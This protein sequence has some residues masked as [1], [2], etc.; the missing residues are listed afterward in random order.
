MVFALMAK[1]GYEVNY[2]KQNAKKAQVTFTVDEYSLEQVILNGQNFSAINFEGNVVTKDKGYAELPYL[3]TNIQLTADK[4]VDITVIDSD[5]TDI[6]LENPLK[7]SRGVIYRNQDPET[8][9]YTINP[10]S[11]KD[12]WYPTQLAEQ[13]MPFI[14]RDIRGT[15]I[16]V[17]PFRYNAVTNTL[18]VYN[19]VTV[20]VTENNETATNPLQA[21]SSKYYR[22]M[23]GIY[24]S[25]FINYNLSKQDLTV[26]EAGDLLVITTDRDLE[27]IQPYVQ[28]KQEKGF[29]VFVE[30]VATGTNVVDLI[31]TKYDE[32]PELLYV[33]LV[34]D[35]ADV[36]VDTD[37]G[38][39]VDPMA[40]CVVGTDVFQDICVGR[41]SAS[42]AAEVTVQ[43]NKTIQYE[44]NPQED[45]EWYEAALGIG[46]SEGASNGDDSEMDK[47]HIQII[48]DNKLDPFTFNNYYPNYDPGA[49]ATTVGNGV[50]AG[51]SWINYCGHGSNT[52][53]VTSGF[54]NNNVNALTNG[55][56]LPGIISVACVNGAYHSGTCFAEAWMRKEN[57]GA[58]ATLM[59]TIN[60][61]WQ[62]P[63]R[64]QD[65]INDI[66]VGGYDYNNNPGNGINTTEQ[67]TT[68][69][70]LAANGM[71]LL[72]SESQNSD[73]LETIKTWV[74]F[75]DASVQMRTAPPAPLEIS[76][77]VILLGTPFTGTITSD[78]SPVEGALVAVSADGVSYAVYTDENG[79]FS[80]DNELQ[81]GDIQLVVT[82]FNTQTIYETISCIPPDGPY[83]IFNDKQLNDNNGNGMFEYGESATVD[84]TMQN[85]G[86]EAAANVVVSIT[87]EDEFVTITNGEA[88]FGD[89]PEGSLLT[90]E[91]AFEF[92]AA[93]NIPD[94]HGILFNLTASDGTDT[95]ESK[96]SIKAYAPVMQMGNMTISD[97][98]GNN[99]GR[100]DAGET[101]D[102]IIAVNNLGHAMSQDMTAEITT[103]S[104][105]ITIENANS[106]CDPVAPEESGILTFTITADESTPIGT[107][108]DIN[109]SGVCGEYSLERAYYTTMGLILEDFETGDFTSFAWEFAGNADWTI[110]N[111]NAFEGNYCAKTGAIDNQ[112][113]TAI[114]ID[115]NVMTAD[116]ISFYY[117][118]SSEAGYDYLRFY[119]DGNQI[120]EWAGEVAWTQFKTPVSEGPHTFKWVYE[121]DYMVTAGSDCAW[122]DYIILP[123]EMRTVVYAGDDAWACNGEPYTFEPTM[124]NVATLSWATSGTGTFNDATMQNATYTP[125]QEDIDNGSV[126]IT[127]EAIGNDDAT[128]TD[129][130][131]L[132]FGMTPVVEAGDDGDICASEI[133]MMNATATYY[134]NVEW[135]TSGDG[136]FDDPTSVEATYTP[137]ENDIENGTVTLSMMAYSNCGN[138]NDFTTLTIN[139]GPE[140]PGAVSGISEV[141]GGSVESYSSEGSANA[142]SY[143]W[144]VKP[145][146]AGMVSEDGTMAT[147][148]WATDFNGDAELK[149]IAANECG[150][151]DSEPV[152]VTITALPA[153]PE[154]VHGIDSVDVYKET[155]SLFNIDALGNTNEYNFTIEPQEAGTIAIDQTDATVTWNTDFVGNAFIRACGMNECGEGTYSAAKT[156]K[157][158]NSVGIN[159]IEASAWAVYPN[160]AKNMIFIE[161]SSIDKD[162]TIEIFNTL[163]A[164]VLSESSENMTSATTGFDVTSLENGVYFVTLKTADASAVKKIMINR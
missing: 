77:N 32:N 67:R 145:A 79:D 51:V 81:P 106:S 71:V 63:M 73:D 125:S 152:M 25:L 119:I 14:I 115:Y 7:P 6:T 76:N 114:T 30:T 82:A 160:P 149:I 155:T 15:S 62:P 157:V 34:G 84:I 23:N 13:K 144:N 116:T 57:G 74:L 147:V 140:A 93:S 36:K 159:D 53:W 118:V 108:A 100:L 148:T 11:I 55:D 129:E 90:I 134:D 28:W 27:A 112:A 26:D 85:V 12:Q 48:Y 38:A 105:Y 68:F 154:M 78:G 42:S 47:E 10:E 52:S 40:G 22:E 61:P 33:Q 49:N 65:Y 66:L 109:L 146:E 35:W 54:N 29:E 60:Q 98:T 56:M 103:T 128:Y 69:G 141:C 137:G 113:S 1:N 139:S 3:S 8:I 5:Y 92:E 111:T 2:T 43:V 130:L 110:D 132:S 107:V 16:M 117:K 75:G 88:N 20:E 91:D 87:T 127:L 17:Y 102:L 70:S 59:S 21:T 94:D 121:K 44:K 150:D 95:W 9:P 151:T 83:V 143:S 161:T 50:N 96:F 45:A 86:V 80:I 162:F 4:N 138:V 89:I 136:I 64:G 39:P 46:S 72:Y 142:I 24:E 104:P 41:F 122:I 135:T 120:Q 123:A 156:V 31:Q 18:R 99:N 163:G 133:F 126:M 37:G 58:I 153:A 124:T 158:Y 19:S 131:T 164:V 97:A 101:A